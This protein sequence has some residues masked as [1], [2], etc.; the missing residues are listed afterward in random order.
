[1]RRSSAG[2]DAV[3]L[4]RIR[5]S[6]SGVMAA[7]TTRSPLSGRAEV[8]VMSEIGS[9]VAMVIREVDIKAIVDFLQSPIDLSAY[10]QTVLQ[11]SDAD[12]R[13]ENHAGFTLGGW[14]SSQK[15]EYG[16]RVRT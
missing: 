16:A 7:S 6:C 5:S 11:D 4:A 2:K 14:S 13:D 9:T 12:K 10:G 1:M 3:R 8:V 15:K